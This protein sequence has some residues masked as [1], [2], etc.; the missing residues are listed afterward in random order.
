MFRSD[1]AGELQEAIL[2]AGQDKVELIKFVIP[3]IIQDLLDMA[4]KVRKS[5]EN[6]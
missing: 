6:L 1:G 4:W 5:S 3:V 2:F